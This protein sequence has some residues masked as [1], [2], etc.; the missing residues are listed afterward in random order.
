M[1]IPFVNYDL[2]T[3]ATKDL[4]IQGADN[5]KNDEYKTVIQTNSRASTVISPFIGK[6]MAVYTGARSKRVY[7]NSQML[8]Y[9]LGCFAFTKKLGKSI[10]N[11]EHNRKKIAKMRRKITQRKVRKTVAKKVKSTS[12]KKK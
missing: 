6:V 10:H 1:K 4:F 3:K 8:G 5:N 11:S 2:Y 9:K 7:V 12:K